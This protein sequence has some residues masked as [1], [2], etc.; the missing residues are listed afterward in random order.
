MN[1]VAVILFLLVSFIPCAGQSDQ[2]KQA[3]WGFYFTGNQSWLA[4]DN[5]LRSNASYAAEPGFGYKAGI[6]FQ[7]ELS[8]TIFIQASLGYV[9]EQYGYRFETGTAASS[10]D[11]QNEVSWLELPCNVNYVFLR[12]PTWQAFVGAGVSVR[13]QLSA[14]GSATALLGNGFTFESSVDPGVRE[15]T[16]LPGIQAGCQLFLSQ[17]SRISFALS[18]QQNVSNWY[19]SVALPEGVDPQW[20]SPNRMRSITLGVTYSAR[21]SH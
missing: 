17:H 7:Q 4:L 5:T 21:L 18:Y 13:R 10:M 8:S 20:D 16:F 9:R 3:L 14:S 15:W 1:K 11:V 19:N 6:N 12:K 2:G